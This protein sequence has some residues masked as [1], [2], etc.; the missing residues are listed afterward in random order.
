MRTER[1]LRT[2]ARW[3]ASFLALVAGCASAKERAWH[4]TG[5][6]EV[7]RS[8]GSSRTDGAGVAQVWVPSTSFRMGTD[9]VSAARLAAAGAPPWVVREL[10]S[11][12]PARTVRVS[13]GYWVDRDE[14][15]NAAFERFVADG[16][17]RRSELWSDAGS[18]WLREQPPGSRPAPCAGTAP[19]L[20]RRCVTWFEA[21][22]YARWR[23]GRLATEAEWELAARGPE[24]RVYPWGDT[25]DA[26]RCNVVDATSATPV[27]S[28]PNGA[29]WV[30]A[31]DMGG[32]AM[33]W[34]RDWLDVAYY[35]SAPDTDPPGPASGT[36]KIEK[37]GWWGSNPFVAR[38][39][40]RHFEDP[41]EYADAHIGFRIVTDEPG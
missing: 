26:T 3:V 38:A 17:Y 10:P 13:R 9:E 22:A 36:V 4:E 41:P 23:G 2:A 29:S 24:S 12:A 32:N 19:D 30:G 6:A 39:A 7:V 33:E 28:F 21:E 40:Y 1:Q 35:A 15:T 31:R 11:E 5:D 37:G 20:P 27:G 16:G 25:F 18:R 34:V 8:A 14:V